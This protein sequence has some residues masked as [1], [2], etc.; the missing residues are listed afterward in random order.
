MNAHSAT[1]LP[2]GKLLVA[3]GPFGAPL[4]SAELY[5]PNP[6]ILPAWQPVLSTVTSP[7]RVGQALTATGTGWRGYGYAEAAGGGANS[8]ATNYPLVQLTRL[9]NAQTVW[10]PTNAF[11][12][13]SLTTLPLND[14]APGYALA[15]VFVNAIPSTAQ[16]IRIVPTFVITPTAGA[17]GAITPAT[18]QTVDFGDSITFT[19]A[20]NAGYHIADVSVDGAA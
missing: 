10:L 4:V 8:S 15:T 6:G 13:T 18:P 17:N 20:A 3:G 9:D 14:F 7:L 16:I 1:L 2:N 11:S 19:I 5:D 12:A